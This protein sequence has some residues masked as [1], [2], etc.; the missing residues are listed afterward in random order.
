[1]WYE[2]PVKI[3]HA[4]ES[5]E[6]FRPRQAVGHGLSPKLSP[7]GAQYLQLKLCSRGQS[8]PSRQKHILLDQQDTIL[9][10]ALEKFMQMLLVLIL[11][12]RGD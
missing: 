8:L 11:R 12:G 7:P 5:S 1:L 4:K 9:T 6:V 3:K 10:E 2:P